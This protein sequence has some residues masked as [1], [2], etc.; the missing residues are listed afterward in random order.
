MNKE[1]IIKTL[2]NEHLNKD[3]L[4]ELLWLLDKDYYKEKPVSIEEF[5]SSKEFVAEKWPNIYPLWKQTLNELFPTPFNAPYNEVLIS[6]GAGS[7]KCWKKGTPMLMYDGTIKKVEDIQVGDQLMGP[8]SKPR[9]VL[10]TCTGTEQM[11]DIVPTRGGETWGCNESHILSLKCGWDKTDRGAKYH[12]DDVWNMSV[13]DYLKRG[14]SARKILRLYRASVDFPNQQELEIDPYIY[15]LWLGD[16][17]TLFPEITNIDKSIIESW[18]DYAKELNLQIYKYPITGKPTRYRYKSD[19]GKKGVNKFRTFIQE[20]TQT[21]HKRILHRYKTASREDRWK[22]LAGIIDIDGYKKPRV[23]TWEITSK[24]EDLAQDYAFIA[25]SL[26]CRVSVKKKE[27][28]QYNGKFYDAW[29]VIISG[30][31]REC[32]IKIERKKADREFKDGDPLKTSFKVID[33]GI[34]EYYGFTIDGDHLCMLGDFTVTHNTVTAT[35]SILYDIYKLGCLK[36]PCEYYRLS[37][38]TMIIMA[39]FSATAATTK[40]NWE[41]IT[42]GITACPWIMRKLVDKRGVER[43][44]GPIVPVEVIPGVFVQT[45]SKFQHS[46][47]KAIFDGLMDEAAFGGANKNDAQKSYNELSSRIKTRFGKWGTKGNTPGQ[48]FLISSPKEA[49]DFMQYRIEEAQKA[50]ARLTKIMQNI[51]VWDADPAKDSDDKFTV[52][53]GNENKEPCIFEPEEEIPEE[54]MDELL[55][56]PMSYYEDFKKDLLISIMNYGGITTTNDMALFKSPTLLNDVSILNNPFNKDVI[57]LPFNKTDKTLMDF[58]DLSYFKNIRHP[59]NNRF[60]HID[61]AY[62]TETLDVYGL[63]ASYCILDENTLISNESSQDSFTRKDRSFFVDFAVGITAPKGQEVNLGKVQDFI[64]Y[65]IKKCNYPVASISADQFQSKQTLQNL[66]NK[67]FKTTYISVDRTRDPY[68]FLRYLVHNKQIM[69]A[70]NEKLKQE[71]KRLRDDGK[72][73]DHPVGGT[74]DIADAVTGSVWNCANSNDI[75][76]K[77]KVAQSI[78]N[79]QQY[80]AE[81]Q[82]LEII[83]FERLKQQFS[84]SI[85]KGL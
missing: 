41:E 57:E 21:G 51:A 69:L 56:V 25:R 63:A 6:A 5:Y 32:P 50:D 76:N 29:R 59:E 14:K 8:D 4:G 82:S 75:L 60:I 78:L 61:A 39:I 35:I 64:E 66:E 53:I 12:K 27:K 40:V 15:G 48:L 62:S 81:S 79:P 58:C 1:N 71:L 73:C 7:G 23:N 18:C 67:G 46:M 85:F 54:L 38:G 72:K 37:P 20:S 52:F 19:S 43:K 70:K 26:G 33:K 49:G 11:Y 83:E 34:G 44:I 30:D 80:L 13:K 31:L 74:K 24:Y 3:E 65:L 2:N 22:L 17:S 28:C 9:N 10:S 77:A 42:Q 55:Y 47:G 84:N 16:G 68:L 45:G 36:D